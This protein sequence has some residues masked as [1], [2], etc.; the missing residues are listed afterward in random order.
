MSGTPLPEVDLPRFDA[1]WA[2]EARA[3]HGIE[4]QEEPAPAVPDASDPE[5]A[6]AARREQRLAERSIAGT[7]HEM[8][9][10][11]E[12]RAV[13]YRWLE[14][15]GAFRAHD[16]PYGVHIDPLQLARNAAHR[17]VA[18]AILADLHGAAP[19]EYLLMLKEAQ[20][21]V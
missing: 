12:I 5:Q 13:V 20:G 17:E 6:R 18:Q 15:C 21:D 11:Q 8:M 4:Q 14:V 19:Q 7:V 1:E 10:V 9:K 16:F 2:A 3:M